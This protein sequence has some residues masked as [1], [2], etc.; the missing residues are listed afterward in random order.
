MPMTDVCAFDDLSSDGLTE[1]EAQGVKVLLAR[2][3]ERVLA[4]GARCPHKGAPL[5]KGLRVGDQVI[6]PWHHAIF[7]LTDGERLEPPARD[8]LARFEARVE[9]GRVFVD[10]EPG[11]AT[12]RPA[13]TAAH[14]RRGGS[15]VYAIVGAGAAGLECADELVAAGFDGRIV[16]ISAED[17][18]PYDRTDLSKTYLQGKKKDDGLPIADRDDLA[19]RGIEWM[20]RAVAVVDPPSRTIRFADG[21]SL[22]YDACFAAPGSGAAPLDLAGADTAKL[23]SLRSHTDAKALKIAADPADSVAIIGSGFIG[24]EAAAA[25]VQSGKRVTVIARDPLPFAKQFGEAVARRLLARHREAGV[26]VLTGATPASAGPGAV[27]LEDGRRVEADLLI[28]AVGAAPRSGLVEGAERAG[29]GLVVDERLMA[30]DQLFLGGDVA[31][32]PVHGHR[33]P[34]RIEHWRVAQQHGRHAARAMMGRDAAFDG[35]PFFWTAQFSPLRYVGHVE[36]FDEVHVEGDLDGDSFTA[37]YVE[38]GIVRAALGAGERDQ[39]PAF[40]ALLRREPAP[41]RE[42]LAAAGWKVRQLLV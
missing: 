40:H 38:G 5:K 25:L 21:G 15:K 4:T 22:A 10:V 14:R 30:V 33:K 13:V 37:F 24:M 35:V 20:N 6:C 9:N 2:S 39:T 16:L 31:S 34:V 7:D 3:G 1:V 28:S 8:C 12:S 27:L 23:F 26:T 17:E 29:R 18:N 19:A 11:A 36:G 41:R 32:F 42:S